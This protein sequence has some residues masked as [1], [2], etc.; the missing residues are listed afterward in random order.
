MSEGRIVRAWVIIAAANLATNVFAWLQVS[1]Y[2]WPLWA[3]GFLLIHG[4]HL[5]AGIAYYRCTRRVTAEQTARYIR[6]R[7]GEMD[8]E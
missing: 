4:A 5:V 1:F 7:A 8:D 6:C 2:D 3:G